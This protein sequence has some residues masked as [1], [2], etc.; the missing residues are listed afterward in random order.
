MKK[1]DVKVGE[2]Y[3]CKVS[4]QLAIVRIDRK[5]SHAGYAGGSPGWYGT[6]LKTGRRIRIQS[7]R[8]LRGPV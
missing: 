4:R 7:A 5:D 2:L 8:R 1:A 6:N 3:W